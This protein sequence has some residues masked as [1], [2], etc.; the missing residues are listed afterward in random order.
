VSR[1][2]LIISGIFGLITVIAFFAWAFGLQLH[3]VQITIV[4]VIFVVVLVIVL[5][6]RVFNTDNITGIFGSEKGEYSRDMEKAMKVARGFWRKMKHGEELSTHEAHGTER[7]FKK[8]RVFGLLLH[9][10][11]RWSDKAGTPVVMVV[12][13]NP[14]RVVYWTD[15]PDPEEQDNPFIKWSAGYTGT[16]VEGLTPGEDASFYRGGIS[17]PSSPLVT[18]GGDVDK[19]L[20]GRKEEED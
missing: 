2:L 6:S 1:T 7:T 10:D 4:A 18:I 12:R 3:P 16:P 14:M 17:K 11:I 20:H 5:I 13:S 9:R 19:F 15:H 8:D